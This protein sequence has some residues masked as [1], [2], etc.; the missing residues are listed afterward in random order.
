[1]FSRRPVGFKEQ[2]LLVREDAINLLKDN[3]HFSEEY[4]ALFRLSA[5]AQIMLDHFELRRQM[6]EPLTV[7]W[8]N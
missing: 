6:L 7:P 2:R 3:H 5:L 4:T 8:H 1:V